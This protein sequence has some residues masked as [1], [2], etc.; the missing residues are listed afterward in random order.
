MPLLQAPYGLSY[1]RGDYTVADRTS[2]RLYSSQMMMYAG[3]WQNVAQVGS[4]FYGPSG[5]R[6][7]RAE[8]RVDIPYYSVVAPAFFGYASAEAIINLRVMDGSRVVASD[9]R[10]LARAIAALFW[11]T[12]FRAS[13]VSLTL[14]AEFWGGYDRQYS[15]H[16]EVETWVGAGGPGAGALASCSAYV[17]EINVRVL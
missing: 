9:R 7:I 4:A 16:V 17:R 10:S 1:K 3:S 15:T 8:A 13:N 12:E 2:G 14:A 11:Y 6:R 5:N